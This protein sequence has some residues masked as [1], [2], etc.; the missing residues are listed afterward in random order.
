[1][2]F[3]P[4]L[5][6]YIHCAST[7]VRALACEAYFITYRVGQN[8][9]DRVRPPV[10]VFTRIH[11]HWPLLPVTP[12]T[13]PLLLLLLL[14][15]LRNTSEFLT[16]GVHMAEMKRSEV[17]EK[18]LVYVFICSAKQLASSAPAVV[19][20]LSVCRQLRRR[21]RQPETFWKA[22]EV[23]TTF[24]IDFYGVLGELAVYK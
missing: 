16:K 19:V 13:S 11:V 6:L 12:A 14:S 7:Q 2:P 17:R 5:Y 10:G 18:M 20:A 3:N 15:P 9:H 4:L 24:V 22:N 21:R 1:M 23:Q 8:K